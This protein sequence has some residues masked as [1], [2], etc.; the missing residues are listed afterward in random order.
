M[1]KK[2]L[3]TVLYALV[4]CVVLFSL[5]YVIVDHYRNT[6]YQIGN[7]ASI[8][9]NENGG[10]LEI[11]NS[12]EGPFGVCKFKDGT[13]C[14]EWDYYNELCE[15]EYSIYLTLDEYYAAIDSS[16]QTNEDCVKKN[17]GNCCGEFPRCVNKNFE[18]APD[19]VSEKCKDENLFSGCGF[20]AFNSCICK[21]T[22]CVIEEL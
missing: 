17:V 18:P 3:R 19:F 4:A 6:N 12:S 2:I 5:V 13:V 21:D 1:K 9:C 15:K 11:R 7:P 14:E 8:F 10:E 16:C 20:V 22:N